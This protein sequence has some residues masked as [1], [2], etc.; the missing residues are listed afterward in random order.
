LACAQIAD[1]VYCMEAGKG[2]V[3]SNVYFVRSGLSWVLIDTGSANCGELIRQAADSLFGLD[4]R[5]SSILI[6]HDHPDHA[7]SALE[8]FRAWGC[9]VYVHPD[10]LPLA[11]GGLSTFAEFASPMDRW[12]VLPLMRAMP[13]RRIEE[14]ISKSS[15]K[16][17]AQALDHGDEA[18]FLPDWKCILAPGHTPGEVAFFRPGDRVLITGDALL[19]VDLNSALGYLRWILRLN[20]RNVAWPPWLTTWDWRIAKRSAIALARTSPSVLASGHGVPISGALLAQQLGALDRCF[21]EKLPL[22]HD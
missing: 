13:R 9:P 12:V 17:V 8:L 21:S 15:L 1:G 22:S 7:G 4:A 20:R 14:M 5:P 3:R 6:T 16:G 18:P 11:T 10:E 2:F 19:T